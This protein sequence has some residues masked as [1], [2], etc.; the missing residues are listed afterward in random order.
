MEEGD[1]VTPGPDSGH[2]VDEADPLGGQLAQRRFQVGD[3]EGHVVEPRTPAFQEAGHRAL[4][5]GGLQQLDGSDEGDLDALRFDGLNGGTYLPR[6]EF[7]E[8][9][10]FLD[11]SDG[12]GDVVEREAVH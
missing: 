3:T 8:R 9:P 4:R 2:F 1:P 10:R 5:V 7:E 12:Y 6:H 11:G